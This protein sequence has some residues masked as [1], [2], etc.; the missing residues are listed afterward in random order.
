MA[1]KPKI[2]SVAKT[3]PFIFDVRITTEE[4]L[5]KAPKPAKKNRVGSVIRQ[6]AQVTV[7]VGPLMHCMV[8][9]EEF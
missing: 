3:I 6:A 8:K 7:Y 9:H 5:H 4:D 2:T 1:K